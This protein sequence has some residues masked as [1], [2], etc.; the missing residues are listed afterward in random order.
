LGDSLK[1]LTFTPDWPPELVERFDDVRG[2]VSKQVARVSRKM[3]SGEGVAWRDA[4][5]LRSELGALEELLNDS[6]KEMTTSEW[7]RAKGYVRYRLK[8]FAARIAPGATLGVRTVA[9]LLAYLPKYGLA[10]GDHEGNDYSGLADA[11]RLAL[12]AAEPQA[13]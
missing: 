2:R 3:A 4:K 10:F 9:E 11:V 1:R 12:S 6:V 7:I 5:S 8:P 13:R